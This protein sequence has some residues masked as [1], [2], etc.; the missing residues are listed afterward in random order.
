M[1]AKAPAK[2][3]I[4]L[5]ITGFRGSYHEI[6]SRFIRYEE[7]YDEIAFVPGRYERFEIEG[8]PDIPREKNIIYKA[9]CALNAATG[10]PKI[11]DFFFS[12]K[13]HV[14]KRIPQGAG[15]G[16]GSSDAAA[17]LK[18]ANEHIGLGLSPKE[19][20]AIGAQIGADVPFFIYGFEAANVRGIGEIIEPF[21]DDIPPIEPRL[22]SIHCDTAAVYANWRKK[23][24]D[25]LHIGLAEH[26]AQMT[27]RR[28]LSTIAPYE[29]NDLY[30][31][32]AD[33]CPELKKYQESWFLSGSGSTIFRSRD[34]SDSHQ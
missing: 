13:V 3:N 25:T 32:A 24:A 19:L 27:S 23:F 4:F 6:V 9:F 12:H 17:F 1:H 5:K 33:L 8:T 14:T 11:I 7:L 31:S 18:L 30:A 2:L 10:N 21:A 26:L 29:A 20:A 15:L 34:E 16:G 28:I 22:L